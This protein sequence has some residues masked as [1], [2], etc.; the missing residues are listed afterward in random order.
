MAEK[1]ILKA[2]KRTVLGRKVKNLRKDGLIA[3][4]VFGAGGSE[5][6]QLQMR[7][8]LK[9]YEETGDTGVVYLE[10]EGEKK[11]RPVLFDEVQV[12]PMGNMW[13]H[14]SLREVN[15]KEKVEAEVPVVLVGENK[16]P[17]T[18]LVT[19]HDSV[20]V[21]ALPTDLPKEFVIDVEK[22]TE[23]EARLTFAELDFDREKVK[24]MIEEEEMDSPVVLLEEVKEEVE[25]VN[26]EG[27]AESVT[28]ESGEEKKENSAE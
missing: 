4:N 12:E 27:D 17:N 1:N 11:M 13:L 5:A 9:M 7:D 10:V 8:T 14:V 21:E 16:V 2:V 20:M 3:A 23:P 24:L 18:V 26:E 19:I 15:L 6:L 28:E 25:E 22:L